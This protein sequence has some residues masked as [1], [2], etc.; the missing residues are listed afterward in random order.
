MQPDGKTTEA[1]WQYVMMIYLLRYTLSAILSVHHLIAALC[2]L[3]TS[4]T[5]V[6][7]LSTRHKAFSLH[8]EIV[9]PSHL[10]LWIPPIYY[11]SRSQQQ[12][13]HWP[14]WPWNIYWNVP[15]QDG[16][17]QAFSE[18]IKHSGIRLCCYATSSMLYLHATR[19]NNAT[20]AIWACTPRGMRAARTR[21]LCEE[22]TWRCKSSSPN[23]TIDS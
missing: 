6:C 9:L 21:L 12:F 14:V 22:L 4:H 2:K 16:S 17:V 10:S 11:E 3:P 23:I 5:S 1:C 8:H 19:N 18:V 15:E 13:K 7:E 20:I